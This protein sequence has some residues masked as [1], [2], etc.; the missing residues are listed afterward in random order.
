MNWQSLVLALA[1][2]A[3]L[4]AVNLTCDPGIGD[5][6]TPQPR[7]FELERNFGW[8]ALYRVEL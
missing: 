4:L 3:F 6:R 7:G 5:R 1:T 8:P 2:F